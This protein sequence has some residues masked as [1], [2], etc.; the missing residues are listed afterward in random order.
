MSNRCK[1]VCQL[2][3]VCSNCSL[4]LVHSFAALNVKVRIGS[5][6]MPR[7]A[8]LVNRETIVLCVLEKFCWYDLSLQLI[9]LGGQY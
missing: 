6:A 9:A 1:L 3:Y 7:L 5:M 2:L 4:F 8:N